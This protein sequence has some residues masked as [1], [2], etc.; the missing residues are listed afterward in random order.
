MYI[1][2]YVRTYVRKYVNIV[3][4]MFQCASV[5]KDHGNIFS[6]KNSLV[7]TIRYSTVRYETA[8]AL[9]FCYFVIFVMILDS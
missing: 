7:C 8:A 3:Q 6:R 9:D 4:K 5:Q 1:Y 2:T